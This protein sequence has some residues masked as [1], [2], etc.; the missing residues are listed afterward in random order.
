MAPNPPSQA[1]WLLKTSIAIVHTRPGLIDNGDE[2]PVA[3][4]GLPVVVET[5]PYLPEWRRRTKAGRAE[6][7]NRDHLRFVENVARLA[8]LAT[9]QTCCPNWPSRSRT[10]QMTRP[11]QIISGTGSVHSTRLPRS[12]PESKRLHQRSTESPSSRPVVQNNC[13]REQLRPREQSPET[14]S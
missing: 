14:G 12:L 10:T 3:A 4:R 2:S 9:A 6:I 8:R 13:R 11:T 7:P 1:S 5:G